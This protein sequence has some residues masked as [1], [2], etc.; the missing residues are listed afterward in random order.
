M[1]LEV[2]QPAGNKQYPTLMPTLFP[3]LSAAVQRPLGNMDDMW[4]AFNNLVK[5]R[6]PVIKGEIFFS[7]PPSSTDGRSSTPSGP[8]PP[9]IGRSRGPP[10]SKPSAW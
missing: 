5:N 3:G 7:W 2:V 10:L 1:I 9:G 4:L 8:R 6:T